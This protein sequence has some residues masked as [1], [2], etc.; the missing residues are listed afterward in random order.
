MAAP[1]VG[2]VRC[3]PDR[4]ADRGRCVVAGREWRRRTVDRGMTTWWVGVGLLVTWL[5]AVDA[6][7]AAEATAVAGRQCARRLPGVARQGRPARRR[8]GP[9][10]EA[11]ARP[12]A[13]Q[14][15]GSCSTD[16]PA[17]NGSSWWWASWPRSVLWPV[18]VARACSLEV[19]YL[20]GPAIRL[21]Q[22]TG[23]PT[24]SVF[25]RESSRGWPPAGGSWIGGRRGCG[26]YCACL[27]RA[28]WRP[29]VCWSRTT[30]RM[31]T[32]AGVTSTHSSSRQNSRACSSDSLRGGISFSVSSEVD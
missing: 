2:M 10:R 16:S 27:R 4:P 21:T 22:S 20:P 15:R 30:L 32:E 1:V 6:G 19:A 5:P 17:T 26:V 23:T 9:W 14:H 31:R 28:A 25:S 24:I 29:R 7:P 13:G 8:P 18:A 11:P 12:R 3:C